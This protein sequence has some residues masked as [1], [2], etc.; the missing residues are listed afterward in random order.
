MGGSNRLSDERVLAEVLSELDGLAL[1]THGLW[2]YALP[3]AEGAWRLG[4]TQG[5]CLGPCSIGQSAAYAL[6]EEALQGA[7]ATRDFMK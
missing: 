6:C 7:P 3:G 2:V 1:A 5:H 4:E